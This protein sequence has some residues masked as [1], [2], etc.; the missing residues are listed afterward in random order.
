MSKGTATKVRICG[1]E[2]KLGDWVKVQYTSPGIQGGII[3]GTV[4]ELWSPEKN[5][6]LQGRVDSGWCFH[7]RDKILSRKEVSA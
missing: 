4:I 3:E 5:N 1:Q 6:H 7:D 2:V